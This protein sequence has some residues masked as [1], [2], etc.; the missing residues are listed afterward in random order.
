MFFRR[1]GRLRKEFDEKLLDQ[2]YKIRDE[3]MKQKSLIKKVMEPSDEIINEMK[4]AEAKY[5]FI[6][7][8]AKK[9]NISVK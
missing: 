2:L 4:I 6:L 5:F 3:R 1:K 9:R 7:K 8:E